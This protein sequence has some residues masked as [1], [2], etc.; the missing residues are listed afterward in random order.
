MSKTIINH[1]MVEEV[2]LDGGGG[3]DY[4]YDT[5]LKEGFV[6]STGRMEGCRGGNF[7]TVAEFKDA[8]PMTEDEYCLK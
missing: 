4:K 8:A 6:Y 5:F 1:P 3:C 7:N 2:L